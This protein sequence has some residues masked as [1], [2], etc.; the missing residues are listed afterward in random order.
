[1]PP[2]VASKVFDR[3]YRADLGR[4]RS[5]GGSGLGLAIVAS[6]TEAHEGTVT[7]TSSPAAGTTV[8]VSLP[9]T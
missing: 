8:T 4:A 6:L 7:C 3:F 1:M 5:Q 2:E 9:L